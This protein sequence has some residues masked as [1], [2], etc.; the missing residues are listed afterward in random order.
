MRAPKSQLLQQ[1]LTCR[2]VHI[3]CSI[4]HT[5]MLSCT[6]ML[7]LP[8]LCTCDRRCNL[9]KQGAVP[10]AAAAVVLQAHAAQQLTEEWHEGLRE[11]PDL[12]L[13][14]RQRRR[15]FRRRGK[16]ISNLV[17]QRHPGLQLLDLSENQVGK[18]PALLLAILLA[19]FA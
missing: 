15:A 10:Q 8:F 3:L 1:E 12:S 4:K 18:G 13:P 17:R 14:A 6:C 5:L 16:E 9:A 19:R 7:L 11:Y 2:G